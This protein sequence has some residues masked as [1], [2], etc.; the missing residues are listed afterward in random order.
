ML[1]LLVMV[2]N[3]VPLR[4]TKKFI[5]QVVALASLVQLLVLVE[6]PN[7]ICYACSGIVLV[8]DPADVRSF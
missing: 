4:R 6:L 2:L 5:P 7:S 8:T 3:M 1:L